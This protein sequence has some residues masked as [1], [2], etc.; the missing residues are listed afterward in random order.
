MK[1]PRLLMVIP[2]MHSFIQQDIQ[3]LSEE[4][5]I[6]INTY[7][8]KKKIFAP[9]F[10]FAQAFSLLFEVPK[11]DVVLVQF[12]GYWS[13]IPSMYG[14]LFKK[15]VYIIL[16]GTDCA[17]IPAL[18]YGSLR[19]PLLKWFC[20]KSYQLAT[21]LLPVSESLIHTTNSYI[22]PKKPV[23]NGLN[24]HFPKLKTPI[25]VIPN[26]FD[27]QFW[28]PELSLRPEKTTFLAVMSQA[29]FY[30]KGGDLIL[31]LAKKMPQ[32]NFK[33]AGLD[34]PQGVPVS[35][36][37]SFLGRLDK[38]ALREAYQKAHFYFQ[39]S[40]YEGFGCALCEAMLCGCKPIV[41]NV[42]A[43]PEIIGTTGI[44]IPFRSLSSLID[45][46]SQ[47]LNQTKEKS[48]NLTP[49][50]RIQ[51]LYPLSFRKKMLLEIL[52]YNLT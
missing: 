3:M 29:Q 33:L 43:M 11:A 44:I 45:Q 6:T 16:H 26:G 24:Y 12:G 35:P 10:L 8:W 30:L 20:K 18:N 39:L 19:I 52:K 48:Y 1:K 46:L 4:Y 31:Q 49:R 36:N 28:S 7:D 37:V 27:V 50:E 13:L 34:C 15:P 17:A 9:I 21:M 40:S 22:D 38:E 2:A 51:S 42:N 5:T 47:T 23:S 32:Y 14:K 41:S 25:K